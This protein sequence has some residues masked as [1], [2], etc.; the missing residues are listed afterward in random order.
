MFA[1]TF[2]CFGEAA[3]L[4]CVVGCRRA[5]VARALVACFAAGRFFARRGC[6][7]MAGAASAIGMYT[8]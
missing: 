2:S 4:R 5:A 6:S 7:E 1:A 3:R 8:I